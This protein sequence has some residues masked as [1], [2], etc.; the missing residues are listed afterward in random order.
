M[1]LGNLEVKCPVCGSETNHIEM[2]KL[3][4][5][6][7]K[8][9]C[10]SNECLTELNVKDN[11]LELKKSHQ[12]NSIVWNKYKFQTLTLNEWERISQ[13]GISNKEQ[14]EIDK[15]SLLEQIHDGEVNLQMVSEVPIIL[16]KNEIPYVMVPS[17]EFHED[18][19]VRHRAGGAVRVMKGV[20]LGGSRSE[21]HPERRLIDTG[22]MI[23][24]N[25][26]LVF[27]GS[28]KGIDI[29]LRKILSI[30]PYSDGIAVNRSNKKNTEW[31][32]GGLEDVTLDFQIEDRSRNYKLDGLILKN[33]IE[34]A[35]SR[36]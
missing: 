19:M 18:R 6:S 9:V 15:I 22:N 27:S 14:D 12:K 28:R 30:E 5:K 21:S 7:K 33:M 35:I 2:K 31:F 3:F 34:G 10:Q 23:L 32:I 20:Y 36:L 11:G 4:F 26:R 29:D 8:Y 16:K 25:K 17:V 24:T 13:G 1:N